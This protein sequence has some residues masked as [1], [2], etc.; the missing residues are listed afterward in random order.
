M[1][2]REQPGSEAREKLL[3]EI[4]THVSGLQLTWET[5]EVQAFSHVGFGLGVG[6][7][8]KTSLQV[9]CLCMPAIHWA[10][11]GFLSPFSVL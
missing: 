1:P 11:P 5:V 9:A 2:D 7:V 10:T 8:E 4:F 6:N 3:S